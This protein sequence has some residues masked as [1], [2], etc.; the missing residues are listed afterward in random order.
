M[1]PIGVFIVTSLLEFLQLWHF[2]LLQLLRSYTLGRLLLGTTF[3]EWDFLYYAL[4]CLIGWWWLR[5]I[6]MYNKV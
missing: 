4:G 3:S 1:I 2:F 5:Q 6:V